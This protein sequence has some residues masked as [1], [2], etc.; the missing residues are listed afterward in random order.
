MVH[1]DSEGFFLE[2]KS[3][4]E[5]YIDSPEYMSHRGRVGYHGNRT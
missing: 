3:V 1:G 4:D 2:E 5:R